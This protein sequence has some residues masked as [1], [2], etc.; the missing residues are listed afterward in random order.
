MGE[1]LGGRGLWREQFA[2]CGVLP[3]H[4]ERDREREASNESSL[5][6]EAEDGTQEIEV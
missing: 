4:P 2:C 3:L 6:A 1:D 5:G